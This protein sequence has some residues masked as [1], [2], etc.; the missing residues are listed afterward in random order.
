MKKVSLIVIVAVALLLGACNLPSQPAD[1]VTNPVEPTLPA[2]EGDDLA[3][4]IDEEDIILLPTNTPEVLPTNTAVAVQPTKE[5]VE[6][7]PTQTPLPQPTATPKPTEEACSWDTDDP[8][9]CGGSPD[10]EEQFDD[11]AY[12]MTVGENTLS[13]AQV[14]DDLYVFSAKSMN[15]PAWR[16]VN[17]GSGALGLSYVETMFKNQT[18][19]SNSDAAGMIFR[20]TDVYNPDQ[21]YL[22]GI[23]CDGQYYVDMWN[24]EALPGGE[25]YSIVPLKASDAINKGS[26]KANR[27]GVMNDTD[28]RTVLYI[29]GMPVDEFTSVI[30]ADGYAGIMAEP[31][32]SSGFSISVDYIKVWYDVQMPGI[33]HEKARTA[34][35]AQAELRPFAFPNF[36]NSPFSSGDPS[37]V[38]GTPTWKD[39]LNSAGNWGAYLNDYA[40]WTGNAFGELVVTGIANQAAWVLADTEKIGEGAIELVMDNEDCYMWDSYGMFFRSPT[41]EGDR[42]YLFGTTCHAQYFVWRWDGKSGRMEK[43]VDFTRDIDHI[44]YGAGKRNRFTIVAVDDEINFYI[45]GYYLTTISDDYWTEGYFGVFVRPQYDGGLTIKLDEASYWINEPAE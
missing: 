12:N 8:A 42:G 43:L 32:S 33:S 11:G 23:T 36:I 9:A 35:V 25:M 44:N 22:F 26:D 34:D 24:G 16:T 39:E 38:L 4:P 13:N 21:G 10:W 41:E 7:P 14:V 1:L 31:A 40:I 15:T 2:A 5:Q 6:D 28:G 27:L 45:N 20:A 30:F 18:C 19:H 37:I 3:E 17:T 29:N